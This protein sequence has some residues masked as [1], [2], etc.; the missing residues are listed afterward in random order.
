MRASECVRESERDR[1]TDI[2]RER[3]TTCER[4]CV[5]AFW[6]EKETV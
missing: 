2:E 3:E 5:T 6:G 4:D 1:Q